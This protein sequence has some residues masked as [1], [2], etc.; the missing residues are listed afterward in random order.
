[1]IA[2]V[3]SPD[4]W[5]RSG[6][7]HRLTSMDGFEGVT[8]FT[9]FSRDGEAQKSPFLLQIQGDGF[10]EID[11]SDRTIGARKAPP[12]PPPPQVWRGGGVP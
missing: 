7:R 3:L 4:A 8:G 2:A 1:M 9:R 6:I 11:M 12:V 10:I 5:L